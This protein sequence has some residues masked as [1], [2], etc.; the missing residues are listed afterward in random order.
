[1]GR[2]RALTERRRSPIV[3]MGGQVLIASP[4]TAGSATPDRTTERRP[5]EG[6]DARGN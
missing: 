5:C 2:I 1:M 4:P 3:F 6:V